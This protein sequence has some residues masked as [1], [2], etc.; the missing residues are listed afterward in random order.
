M[1]EID[2][3][4]SSEEPTKHLDDLSPEVLQ[5]IGTAVKQIKDGYTTLRKHI[6]GDTGYGEIVS[7]GD[8]FSVLTGY[9]KS[10]IDVEP[11][12]YTKALQ[13]LLTACGSNEKI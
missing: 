7:A 9:A 5:E 1:P 2:F 8:M 4:Q 6:I 11:K 12:K 3:T 10:L 13:D